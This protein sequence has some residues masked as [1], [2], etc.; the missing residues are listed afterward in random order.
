MS[1]S[2][3]FFCK[4]IIF[5]ANFMQFCLECQ[6]ISVPL[7]PTVEFFRTGLLLFRVSIRIQ[8]LMSAIKNLTVTIIF[9][10]QFILFLK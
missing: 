1:I 5:F 3:T 4:N 9:Y 2:Y 6:K 7:P 10:L 8:V